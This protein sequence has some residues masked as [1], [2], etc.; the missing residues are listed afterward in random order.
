MK[1]G[2]RWPA[3]QGRISIFA[4]LGALVLA[5]PAGAVDAPVVPPVSNGNYTVSYQRCSSCIADWLEER[6]GDSGAW[7]SAGVGPVSYTNKPDGR[8]YYRVGYVTF[9]A[10]FAASTSYSSTASVLVAADLPLAEP[11]ENQLTYRYEVRRGDINGDGRTDLFIAR[12][13]GGRAGDGTIDAL[14]LRQRAN[15][16]LASVVPSSAQKTSASAWARADIDIVLKDVNVDGFADVVLGR[17]AAAVGN[18]GVANQ[19]VYAPGPI[20]TPVVRGIDA[21]FKQFAG[22]M[23]GYLRDPE[24]F[25][26]NAPV[27]V[28]ARIYYSY[29]CAYPT[30]GGIEIP[31]DG[32]SANCYWI[33]VTVVQTAPDYSVFDDDAVAIWSL[34]SAI[35]RKAIS[36]ATGQGRI[37]DLVDGVAGTEVGGWGEREALDPDQPVLESDVRRGIELFTALLRISEAGAAEPEE[38]ANQARSVDRVYVT[39][40][41]IMGFLPFHTALEYAGST[42]S[43]H[44]SDARSF[45]DGRLV[46]E[47]N[48]GPDRPLLMMTLG[49]VASSLSTTAYWARLRAADAG[50]SDR[51]P[52]D[53]LPSIGS[54]GYN[55]NGYTHGLMLATGGV[56]SIDM[57][58][59]VGGERPVPASEY[60]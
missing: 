5:R 51:L 47:V 21:P 49:T 2:S 38:A 25:R 32:Y 24:Y 19:V 1:Q 43:A 3:W 55:S 13:R 31:I 35:D 14:L 58:E 44:D 50:Y 59:F 30:G 52:Y 28:F 33:P 16:T 27:T 11:L 48:W 45:V 57:N 56:P 22:D 26:E 42:I 34:E 20:S 54:G 41:R 29:V 36:P 8:Y 23:A 4:A 39:G 6:S 18:G 53:T 17:V 46:S 40:R 12:K 9:D 60:F 10:G 15:G 7:Q 37:A